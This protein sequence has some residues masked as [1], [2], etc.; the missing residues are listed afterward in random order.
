MNSKLGILPVHD[1]KR[2]NRRMLVWRE[3]MGDE[4]RTTLKKLPR[5]LWS[6]PTPSEQIDIS[7][8]LRMSICPA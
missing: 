6:A 2:S 4:N 5:I 1:T 3:M 7:L 8:L